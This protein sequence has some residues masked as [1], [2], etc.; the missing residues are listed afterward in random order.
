MRKALGGLRHLEVENDELQSVELP[1]PK[2]LVDLDLRSYAIDS[3]F[4][5]L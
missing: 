2:P 3:S 5:R 4:M 1:S